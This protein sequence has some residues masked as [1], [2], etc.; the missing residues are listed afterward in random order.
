MNI[1]GYDKELLIRQI[2]HDHFL[3]QRSS[4]QKSL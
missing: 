1:L 2:M 3:V 4:M